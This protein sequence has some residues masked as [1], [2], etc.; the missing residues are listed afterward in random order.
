MELIVAALLITL[1]LCEILHFVE[2]R[3]MLNRLMARDLTEYKAVTTKDEPNEVV[4]EDETVSI[5]DAE[6]E[7]SGEAK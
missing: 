6:E 5:E 3:D 7:L 1:A 4:D 2:R